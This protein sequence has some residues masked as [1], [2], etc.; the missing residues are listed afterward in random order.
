[1]SER[2]DDSQQIESEHNLSRRHFLTTTAA[3]ASAG[4]VLGSL[5]TTAA[6]RIDE[7]K[8]SEFVAPKS[9]PRVA[10]KD[11]DPIRM[12]VIGTGGMGT[13]HCDAF[14]SLNAAGREKVQIVALADVCQPRL[15]HALQKCESGQQMK[16]DAYR[17]Y[18]KLLDRNDVHAVLIAS[19]EHW[20]SK[21]AIDSIAAGK[22][23]YLEKPMTLN[24]DDA[25]Q[26]HKCMAANPDMILQVGT[27]M[28]QLPK[29]KAAKK[30]L[31]DGMVG[32]ACWSQTSYC[33]NSKDGEWLYYAIDPAW[34]PGKNLDWEEW[35]GPLGKMKWDPALYARWRRY[36]KTSTGIIGDLLVHVMTPLC[37]A[38]DMGWP[39]RVT[40]SGGHYVDKA[41]ENHDQVNLTVEFEKDHTLVVAGSTCNENGLEILVRGHEGTLYLGGTSPVFRPERLFADE[42]EESTIQCEDIGNDQDVHRLAWMQCIRTR[43]QPE[44]NVEMGTKIMVIVDLATRSMWE[45]SAFTF[46]PKTMKAKKA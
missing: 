4:I 16:V 18:R 14:M 25:V 1:M 24:L 41:M 32:K 12:G 8:G 6:A 5:G 42:R 31:A 40:A 28:M 26:L 15:D 23:V 17:D 36:R 27:Q 20:H 13:G 9:K 44:G 3:T 38:L 34:E 21:H 19:P 33:R 11:A 22:D 30:V 45:G 35:C 10:L 7:I 37:Y 43:Q 46:D 39:T 2:H 29:Y